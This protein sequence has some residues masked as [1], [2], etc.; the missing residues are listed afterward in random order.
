MSSQ[1]TALISFVVLGIIGL[2]VVLCFPQI[3]PGASLQSERVNGVVSRSKKN[4]FKVALPQASKSGQRPNCLGWHK[5][6][7]GDT[8][9]SIAQRFSKQPGQWQWIKS[10][11]WVSRK[12]VGDEDLKA[13]ESVCVVWG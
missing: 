13:G 9:W 12:S 7:T 1:L 3:V 4:S 8:Q 6:V 2:Y 11:R 5:V 10:M